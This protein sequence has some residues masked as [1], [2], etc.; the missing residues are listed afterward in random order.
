MKFLRQRFK[1]PRVL[2]F[3]IF[4]LA[5]I[6]VLFL[7][8]AFTGRIWGTIQAPFVG[9]G[10]FVQDRTGFIFG[11]RECTMSR[12]AELEEQRASLALEI[13]GVKQLQLENVQLRSQLAYV[14]RQHATVRSA[15]ITSRSVSKQST[16]FNI[17]AGEIDGLRLGD[18]VIVADGNLVGKVSHLQKYSATVTGI[19]DMHLA[20]AVSLLNFTRTIGIAKG[21]IGDLLRLDFIPHDENLAVGDLV[22][23]SGLEENVPSGLLVGIITAVESDPAEPFQNAIIEPL[24][25]ISDYST[26]SVIIQNQEYE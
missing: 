9:A 10:T 16:A 19:T 23:T 2:S 3:V 4:V 12:L 7:L 13:S 20:T 18:P 15:A 22:V 6:F 11:A 25:K 21:E 8:R 26:V 17:N 24:T 5:A 1:Q 14:E